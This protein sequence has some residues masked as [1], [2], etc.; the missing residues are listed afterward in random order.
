VAVLGFS[1]SRSHRGILVADFDAYRT[2]LGDLATD[3]THRHLLAQPPF[4]SGAMEDHSL[5][6]QLP[7][8]QWA[9]PGAR[10]IPVYVGELA[11]QEMERAVDA[12]SRLVD[13]GVCILAST[14]F[15]HYGRS[16]GYTPFP[17]DEQTPQKLRRIDD[18]LM[19][20]IAGLDLPAFHRALRETGSNLCGVLPVTLLICTLRGLTPGIV[21]HVLD[22]RTSGEITG[23]FAHSVSYA[24][25][26][27]SGSPRSGARWK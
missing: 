23:S 13:D 10:L 3:S 21:C 27:F 9:A 12:L 8:L 18:R 19:E 11:P 25:M 17:L 1:H 16:F 22:Y 5:E 4:L 15:T 26:S 7:L 2:P 24:A 14:D 6:M 20:A